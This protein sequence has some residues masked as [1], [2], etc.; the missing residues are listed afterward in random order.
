M[1][2]G[3]INKHIDNVDG[4]VLSEKFDANAELRKGE[5]LICNDPDNPTIYIMDTNGNPKKITGGGSGE[6][7]GEPY[8]DT[9]IWDAVNKNSAAIDELEENGVSGDTTIPEEIV[10]A[11]L[12]DQL[13]AG[14]YNNGDVIP[15]GT[16]V[17]TILQ[18]ILCKELYPSSVNGKA[19]TATAKMN[20]LTVELTE[21]GIVE[22]GTVVGYTASTN[23]STV[24]TTASSITGMSYG[25]STSDNDKKE[26][27]ATSISKPCTTEIADNIYTMSATISGFN[28]AENES[29]DFDAT[30][31]SAE[32]GVTLSATQI[33]CVKE[34]TNTLN[35]SAT[36][37]SYSYSAEKIDK[38]YYCSNLGKTD[39]SKYHDGITEVSGTTEKATKNG[40]DSVTGAY[41]YFLG[42]STNTT[43]DQFDTESLRALNVRTGWITK[44]GVT[45]IVD[46]DDVLTSNGT[47]IVV[48]CP[49]E[50]ILKSIINGVNANIMGNFSSVGHVKYV[51]N[52]YFE[53]D[54][55]VYVYPITNGATVEFKNVTLDVAE[56]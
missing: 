18:N 32:G 16:D 12:E 39:A 42:Y 27:T 41:K 30:A 24:S 53:T 22:V 29:F 3:I 15:A 19:A 47:S 6:G 8:D 55:V 43:F 45:T 9:A 33:G 2:K 21:S 35:V 34:G 25:Y 51:V 28:M 40:T 26:N 49:S 48:A 37:A 7:G 44:G 50:Y 38:V 4:V 52:E 11:G 1:A 20:N 14:N 10:V 13:G 54:Y 46:K 5:I 17:Y 56:K 31:Q 36:G 23:G